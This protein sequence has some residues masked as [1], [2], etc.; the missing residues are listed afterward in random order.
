MKNE[1]PKPPPCRL[2][3][4]CYSPKWNFLILNSNSF[5]VLVLI[6]SVDD[7]EKFSFIVCRHSTWKKLAVENDISIC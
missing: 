7:C 1:K 4:A 3:T 6:L 2:A 5:K